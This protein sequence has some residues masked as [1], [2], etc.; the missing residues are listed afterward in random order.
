MEVKRQHFSRKVPLWSAIKAGFQEMYGGVSKMEADL[1]P[2]LEALLH[3]T[4]QELQDRSIPVTVIANYQ[5][6]LRRCFIWYPI[7]AS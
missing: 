4:I 7:P 1:M 3:C 6:A 2:R 5:L